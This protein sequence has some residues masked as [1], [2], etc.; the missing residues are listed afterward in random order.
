MATAP[1]CFTFAMLADHDAELDAGTPASIVAS[2]MEACQLIHVRIIGSGRRLRRCR[3]LVDRLWCR[4]GLGLIALERLTKENASHSS[5]S[6]PP[7]KGCI[8]TVL[9]RSGAG[10][11]Q[12]RGHN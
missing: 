1:L 5:S 9:C 3:L 10:R 12:N 8:L 7:K 11:D 6:E 4:L 2:V